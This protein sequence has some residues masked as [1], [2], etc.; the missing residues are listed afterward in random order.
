[1]GNRSYPEY[2][3]DRI[4]SV[5]VVANYGGSGWRKLCMIC[6]A[7]SCGLSC[8][9]RCRARVV[10]TEC[11]QAV[12]KWRGSSKRSVGRRL[13]QR[14]SRSRQPSV[15]ALYSAC[16]RAL[17]RR[18]SSWVVNEVANARHSH[19]L[20]HRDQGIFTSSENREEAHR[21]NPSCGYE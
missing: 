9:R 3:G 19:R 6:C 13:N 12:L 15:P 8:L 10:E 21:K 14:R 17:R 20:C 2:V 18:C 4:C 1:M 11:S 7:C 5:L 16:I